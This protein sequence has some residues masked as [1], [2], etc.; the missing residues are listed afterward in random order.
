LLEATKLDPYWKDWCVL[1]A[2]HR[3]S[4]LGVKNPIK[5]SFKGYDFFRK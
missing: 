3:L 2:T 5:T 1:F 4:K